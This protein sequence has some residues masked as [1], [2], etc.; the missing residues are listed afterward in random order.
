[1]RGTIYKRDGA[2]TW[3]IVYDAPRDPLTGKRRQ[4]SKGG[5]RTKADA[6]AAL[7]EILGSM[8]R[9]NYV[10]PNKQTVAEYLTEWLDGMRA[11]VRPSTWESYDRNVRVHII[12]NLGGYYLQQLT[13]AILDAFYAELHANGRRATNSSRTQGPGLSVRTVHYIHVLLSRALQDAVKKG[14]L[15]RN[16]AKAADPPTQD[17]TKAREMQTWNAEELRRFL[18]FIESDRIYGPCLIAAFTGLRRG[19][20]LGLRWKDIDLDGERLSVRQTVIAVAHEVTF[21]TPKNGKARAV[22]LDG[23]TV[24]ALRTIRK[25]QMEERLALAGHYQ[26]H[27]LVFAQ[28]DGSPVHPERLTMVFDRRVA[29][30]GLPRLRFHDLR[31]THATLALQA[32]VH[33]KVVQERLGHS[34]IAITLDTYS[35]VIPSMQ[36][37]AARTIAD[38]ILG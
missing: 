27:G 12:P 20:V 31:H 38:F 10:E 28:A 17:G 23:A 19:E 32:G 33:P 35:H 16:V 25:A 3:T 7:T 21:S 30:S 5:F 1:M 13:P 6:Q 8:D 11:R 34:S 18:A 24:N 2:Q 26:D 29:K 14:S 22:T 36:E 9:G 4:R 15:V 37:Q